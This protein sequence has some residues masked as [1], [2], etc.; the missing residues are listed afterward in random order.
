MEAVMAA[1]EALGNIAVDVS[2][3]KVG[4][5]IEAFD[6][7]A[8][9]MRFI[10]VKGRVE[11]ADTI[12]VTRNEVITSLHKPDDYILAIVPVSNGFASQPRYV[13]NPFN[14]EPEFGV[15]ALQIK[16]E[17]L[18]DRAEAPA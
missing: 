8:K 3:Q 13:R 5:D 17:G 10:E 2:A 7:D 12:M 14:Q 4:Y 6:P 15:T 16:L 1:E 18:L 9:R 11:G